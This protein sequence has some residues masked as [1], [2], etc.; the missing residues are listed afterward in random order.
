[1]LR[2]QDVIKFYLLNNKEEFLFVLEE[3]LP[4]IFLN[5]WYLEKEKI[6]IDDLSLLLSGWLLENNR[7]NVVKNIKIPYNPLASNDTTSEEIFSLIKKINR[8]TSNIT[9]DDIKNGAKTAEWLT[10]I[11]DFIGGSTEPET[12]TTTQ[13]TQKINPFIVVAVI[14]GVI[15]FVVIVLKYMPL[16]GRK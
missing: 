11:G 7:I 14:A 12:T 9:I 1:M 13:T 4:Q 3:Y 16:G 2:L 10:A 15:A 8:D 6:N 5:Q